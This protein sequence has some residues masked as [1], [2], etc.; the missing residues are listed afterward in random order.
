MDRAARWA[1]LSMGSQSRTQLSTHLGITH[2]K[3]A[4]TVSP[5]FSFLFCSTDIGVAFFER[6]VDF[7]RNLLE[8]SG[9]S[10]QPLLPLFQ[11][12]IL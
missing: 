1:A 6:G 11:I 9:I 12:F 8:I 7:F 3:P 4:L 10:S 2:M 5:T